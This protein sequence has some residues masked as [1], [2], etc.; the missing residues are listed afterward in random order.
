L[1]PKFG[2]KGMYGAKVH[3]AVLDQNETETG[4]TIHEVNE[5]YDKGRILFQKKIRINSKDTVSS[6]EKN[7]K[8]LEFYYLPRV[9]E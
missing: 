8:E 6:I 3:Q 4:I 9:I 5:E 7:I 2:G 1:L